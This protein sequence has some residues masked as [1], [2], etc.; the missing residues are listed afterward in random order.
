M[1]SG[2]LVVGQVKEGERLGPAG[3][4][5]GDGVGGRRQSQRDCG[6]KKDRAWGLALC[7]HRPTPTRDPPA[8]CGWRSSTGWLAGRP[9]SRNVSHTS[10]WLP[11]VLRLTRALPENSPDEPRWIPGQGLQPDPSTFSW[12]MAHLFCGGFSIVS[13]TASSEVPEA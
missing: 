1:E 7:F 12:R 8:G 5:G 11:L 2:N 9:S 13:I 4:A 3:R 10:G 6:G